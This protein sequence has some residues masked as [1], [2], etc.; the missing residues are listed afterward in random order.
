MRLLSYNPA[1]VRSHILQ[2]DRSTLRAIGSAIK[3]ELL[4]FEV[5]LESLN[6]RESLKSLLLFAR[7]VYI[8]KYLK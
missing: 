7:A 3:S 6:R 2:A 5:C 8:G 4:R 1:V